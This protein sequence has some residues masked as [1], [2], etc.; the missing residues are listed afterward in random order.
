MARSGDAV[1]P[2]VPPLPTAGRAL[3]MRASLQ[4]I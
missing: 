2:L 3:R 1:P 4:S